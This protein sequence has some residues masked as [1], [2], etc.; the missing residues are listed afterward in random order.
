M[1]PSHEKVL[2]V[3]ALYKYCKTYLSVRFTLRSENN[4]HF[5]RL[6]NSNMYRYFR[7]VTCTSL[8]L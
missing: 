6:S 5:F 4:M 1:A 8:D 2:L 3:S 7:L